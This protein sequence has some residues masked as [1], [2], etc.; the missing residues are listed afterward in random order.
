MAIDADTGIKRVANAS[1]P[2]A[3]KLKS[4][5]EINNASSGEADH[6]KWALVAGMKYS[7]LPRYFGRSP[8]KSQLQAAVRLC[9]SGQIALRG[10]DW[11][12]LGCYWGKEVIDDAVRKRFR[13]HQ[14]VDTLCAQPRRDR[15]AWR[16]KEGSRRPANIFGAWRNSRTASNCRSS[17]FF[18]LHR[19]SLGTKSSSGIAMPPI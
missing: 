11:Q 12:T 16:R 9:S 1:A 19:L 17:V 14:W 2:P 15:R 18:S 7:T 3:R 5:R 13:E 6:I 8:V 10:G 4:S